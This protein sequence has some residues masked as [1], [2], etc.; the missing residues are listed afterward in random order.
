MQ[1]SELT[2][3]VLDWRGDL[4]SMICAFLVGQTLADQWL[5]RAGSPL[6]TC[7]SIWTHSGAVS[8]TSLKQSDQ[9][10]ALYAACADNGGWY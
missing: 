9:P 2:I 5:C 1:T 3:A 4:A 7:C 10:A 8:R 6:G